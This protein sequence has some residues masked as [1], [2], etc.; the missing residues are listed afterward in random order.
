MNV[1]CLVI[2]IGNKND[3]LFSVVIKELFNTATLL[4]GALAFY[5]YKLCEETQKLLLLKSW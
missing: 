3:H 1:F 4:P 2:Q 5:F